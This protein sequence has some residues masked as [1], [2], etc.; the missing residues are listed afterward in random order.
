MRPRAS[1]SL[2]NHVPSGTRKQGYNLSLSQRPLR[3][4]RQ[5][6]SIDR[7]VAI[8][9]S[10]SHEAVMVKESDPPQRGVDSDGVREAVQAREELPTHHRQYPA[11][12]QFHRGKY[13]RQMIALSQ[14][15]S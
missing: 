9:V 13:R 3:S 10:R 8:S 5:R 6:A 12:P 11:C 2:L 1:V 4:A 14:R 15:S 7:I